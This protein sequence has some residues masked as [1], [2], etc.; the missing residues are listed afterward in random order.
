MSL[1]QKLNAGVCHN[2]IEPK[3]ERALKA[4]ARQ[5]PIGVYE[6]VAEELSCFPL[7]IGEVEREREHGPIIIGGKFGERYPTA[8]S[9]LANQETLIP[10][11]R[12]VA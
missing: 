11:A 10:V 5:F 3:I 7:R 9:R 1:L 8:G 6:R 4:I 12:A 2:A